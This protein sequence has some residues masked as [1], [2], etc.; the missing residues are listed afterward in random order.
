MLYKSHRGKCAYCETRI[1]HS[2]YGDVEH[3]RP[4]KGV[5]SRNKR[6]ELI[7]IKNSYFGRAFD[8]DSL[9]LSCGTRNEFYKKNY[10]DLLPDLTLTAEEENYS[11]AL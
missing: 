10:F 7:K 6:G 11:G 8:W 3:F 9:F 2:N 5:D 1:I 4:K